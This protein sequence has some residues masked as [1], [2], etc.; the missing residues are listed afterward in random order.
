MLRHLAN[1]PEDVDARLRLAFHYSWKGDRKNARIEV[2]RVLRTSPR[3][4][5]AHVLLARLD[6]WDRHYT[7][8]VKRIGVLL[9][10]LA[11][12]RPALHLLLDIY[13]WAHRPKLARR[14]ATRLLK[15]DKTP[16]L[17]YKLALIEQLDLN[18]LA[19]YRLAGEAIARARSHAGA[20]RLRSDTKL[21]SVDVA[22]EAEIF[23]HLSGLYAHSHGIVTTAAIM[24]R[25][26]LSFTVL[27][28]YRWRFATHNHRLI[29]QADWRVDRE[30]QLSLFGGFGLPAH[31]VPK[32]TLGGAAAMPLGAG[33]DGIVS[34][35]YDKPAWGGHLH[36]IRFD[37]GAQLPLGFRVET[38]YIAGLVSRC[39]AV[40][41]LHGVL[42]RTYW[43]SPRLEA[44][45]QYGFGM[46]FDR[47]LVRGDQLDLFSGEG[48]P[49]A[50]APVGTEPLALD[51]LRGHTVGFQVL[52][53]FTRRFLLRAGYNLQLRFDGS[54]A[55]MP[56]LACRFW[57]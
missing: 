18:F 22:Y 31:A 29:L 43:L 20:E 42:L 2:E 7:R 21:L 39:G 35:T 28:E 24:P 10:K 52:Y 6:A 48:C 47:P 30:L 4:W 53:R 44:Y 15:R 1:H 51:E 33:F 40:D 3:Y 27:D 56:H 57:F 49:S 17:L 32:L 9:P 34:Y 37:F 25:S 38:A 8:A 13:I 14:V 50:D 12:R 26:W 36:R 54:S 55:H 46:E 19:A 45:L 11:D 41:P 16:E 5:D 23:P